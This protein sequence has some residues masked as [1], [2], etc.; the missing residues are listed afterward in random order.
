M[1]D[2]DK[3]TKDSVH[4]GAAAIALIQDTA[5]AAKGCHRVDVDGDDPIHVKRFFIPGKGIE[6]I[7]LEPLPRAHE[8][9]TVEALCALANAALEHEPKGKPVVWV[10]RK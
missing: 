7:V 3:D 2:D 9:H 6:E 8:P 10:D 1:H 5:V 4:I